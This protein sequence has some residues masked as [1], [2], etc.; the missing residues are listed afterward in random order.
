MPADFEIPTGLDLG[1]TR[2]Y[3]EYQAERETMRL[4]GETATGGSAFL[5]ASTLPLGTP[6]TA[7]EAK[8]AA[9]G[10]QGA[11]EW[12]F[13]AGLELSGMDRLSQLPLVG[14]DLHPAD[15]LRFEQLGL[16]IASSDL[17]DV[18]VPHLPPVATVPKGARLAAGDAG[19][20]DDSAHL[21]AGAQLSVA[22]GLSVYGLI[23]LDGGGHAGDVA[24][25]RTVVPDAQLE[26]T[27][28]F[29]PG[30]MT[31]EASLRGQVTIPSG[32]ASDLTLGNTTLEL[33]VDDGIAFRLEGD[34]TTHLD[35]QTIDVRPSIL[36]SPATAKFSVDIEFESGW[37]EPMGIVGLTLDEVGFSMAIDFE[38]P[39]LELG[40]EGKAH[41]GEAAP[42]TDDFAFVLELVEEVPDPL[43]LSFYI[44]ELDVRTALAVF[45][46][47]VD[48]SAL[49]AFVHEIAVEN[50]GFLWA[51]APVT[52]PD[53]STVLP[54]LRFSGNLAILGF[55]AHAALAIDQTTGIQG[56]LEVGP[57]HVGHILAVTGRGKGVRVDAQAGN[58]LRPTP[59]PAATAAAG[60]EVVPPGGAVVQ[61]RTA[62][63]PFLHVSMIVSLLDLAH[64]EV[65]ALVTDDGFRFMLVYS[66][67]D[68]ATAEL[69]V[70]LAKSGF[71]LDSHV[72]LHLAA[73]IGPVTILGADMG[74][75]HLDAGFDLDLHLEATD[76]EFK[77][78]IGGDFE[79]EGAQLTL[80]QLTVEVAPASLTALPGLVL[81]HVQE[82]A[83]EIFRDLF[84]EAGTLLEDAGK[85][86]D[87]WE[88]KAAEEV[89]K[90]EK[91]SADEAKRL[92]D[93]ARQAVA[94]LEG[95]AE[96][97]LEDIRAETKKI[98]TAGAA[99]VERIRQETAAA[100]AEI[101]ASITRVLDATAHEVAAIGEEI[102]QEAEAVTKAVAHAVAEAEREVGQIVD[103]AEQEAAKILGDAR[104]AAD[105]VVG[106]AR[107]V[108]AAI[109][110][111]AEELLADAKRLAA[112]A[113]RTVADAGRALTRT[114]TNAWN[115]ITGQ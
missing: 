23:D 86:V 106:A 28:A 37:A 43:L 113:E 56:D 96:Q 19:A 88:K 41:I 97:Q 48:A 98:E 105:A 34:L 55:R 47:E 75:L 115:L 112:A 81:E 11:G 114:A 4:V 94:T 45:A 29:A 12:S 85:E 20:A 39:G 83:D 79:F 14:A 95:N 27:A 108:C 87:A 89:D 92:V 104:A 64:V 53:G 107:Q 109:E 1:L 46:P 60:Q 71:H 69:D 3:L 78:A 9:D 77:L 13:L 82:H 72:G 99:Q 31:L 74:L 33:V 50:L 36:I 40:L 17:D 66:V 6:A 30:G 2:I 18:A 73:D 52:L 102:A 7:D 91:Q 67:T 22:K 90:L 51:D 103:A 101:D 63:S 80:P 65:E 49:P 62:Q 5:L 26:V 16:L 38:P 10:A 58:P 54:G 15:T 8:E 84:D 76:E 42:S 25:L 100:V 35:A 70:L 93:G 44:A 59:A 61:F 111:E 68:A 21:A 57:I 24:L 32:G 110:R